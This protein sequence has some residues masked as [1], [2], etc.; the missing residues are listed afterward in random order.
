MS[1]SRY[2]VYY[3]PAADSALWRFGSATLGY[4]ALTGADLPF[5]VPPGCDSTTWPAFTEEPR[6]YGFHATLKAP[7][8][9]AD[10]RN[11]EQLRAFARNHAAGLDAVE[12][13]GLSVTALG[14]FVA[15]TPSA[16]SAALQRFAFAAVQAFEL[17]RAPLSETD[18]ARRLR[19]PLTPAQHAYLEAYGY[20]YVGDAFR[21]HMTLTGS[22]P[23]EQA[24]PVKQALEAAYAAALPAGP[25]RI[26][27]FALFRQDERAGRFRLL[28]SYAF[29]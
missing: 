10:G 8:E 4:D 15:L 20:P 17:F 12:L 19:S 27:R 21:F 13:A 22:L 1:K 23:G 28:D 9:L 6:R 18:K 3:A 7:F 25:I 14:S 16:P 24:A 2:A 29:G 5:A 11:E 26:D